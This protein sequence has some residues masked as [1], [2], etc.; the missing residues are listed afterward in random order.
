MKPG[1]KLVAGVGVN[2]ADYKVQE[3]RKNYVCP[4]YTRWASMLA[5]CYSPTNHSQHHP[6][7]K[8][9]EVTSEWHYFSMFRQWHI[10]QAPSHSLCLDKDLKVWENRVYGPDTCAF[11]TLQLN[12]ALLL[13]RT[14]PGE[15][16][17]GVFQNKQQFTARIGLGGTTRKSLGTYKTPELAYQAY[18][19]AKADY[20]LTFA[21]AHP[22]PSFWIRARADKFREIASDL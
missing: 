11:I 5:R 19:L 21:P 2:D 14:R 9:C 12:N 10:E 8:D 3:P 6:S 4:I 15:L 7:Y 1:I 18:L 17:T 16:P 20:L 13:N 22:E